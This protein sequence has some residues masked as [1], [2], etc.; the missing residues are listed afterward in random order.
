MTKTPLAIEVIKGPTRRYRSILHRADGV[1][2]E[3]DGGSYN[4]L[5]RR[6]VPHDIAHLIVEDEL[7]LDGGVWGVLAAGG[8]FRGAA[9]KSGR[10][11]PHATRRGREIVAAST[12]SLNHAE[13]LV[14]TVCDLAGARRP[15]EA[16]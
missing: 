12:A 3:L 6:E 4:H 10:Q 5:G 8:L 2:V 13:G 7:G 9:V 1:E 16:A 11:K 15:S 14:R